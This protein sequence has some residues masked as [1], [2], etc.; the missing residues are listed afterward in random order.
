MFYVRVIDTR[1]ARPYGSI[2]VTTWR[3]GFL[4]SGKIDEQYADNDGVVAV[5]L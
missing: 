2:R 1:G 5:N 4:T 3:S